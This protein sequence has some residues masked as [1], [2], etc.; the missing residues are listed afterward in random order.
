[1]IDHEAKQRRVVVPSQNGQFRI[2]DWNCELE[3]VENNRREA[4]KKQSRDNNHRE[5]S[6]EE[7]KNT[8][9]GTR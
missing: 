9:M 5:R 6:F 8:V 4:E 3:S 1:M 7:W 2:T